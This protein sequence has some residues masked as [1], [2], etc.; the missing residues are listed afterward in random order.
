MT[1]TEP[2]PRRDALSGDGDG[3]VP[4]QRQRNAR[5]I[6]SASLIGLG[7]WT[8]HDFLPAL[9]WAA[10][11]AV[12]FWP[13]YEK[14]ERRFPPGKHNVLLPGLFTLCIGLLFG[15]PLAI[16]LFEVV[17]EF[18][19]VLDLYRQATTSGIPVPDF[20][21]H[22]PFGG[23]AVTHWWQDNLANGAQTHGI[24]ERVNKA[25]AAEIGRNVGGQIVHRTVLFFFAL[26]T[27]FFLFKQGK[28]VVRQCLDASNKA[29]GAKGERVARQMVASIHGTVDG[30]VLVGLGEG[31]LMGIAYAFAGVPHP[32]LFGAL[33]AVAAMVPFAVTVVFILV[34]AVLV[35]QGAVVAALLVVVGG[36]ILAFLADHLVRP[37]LIGGTTRLPFLWVL[38]GILGGV[39]TWGLVGLFVGP[40]LMAALVLL[41]R[42]YTEGRQAQGR[43]A[44]AKPDA[45]PVAGGGLAR[46]N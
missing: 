27:L 3:S 2:N 7:V 42:E 39:E 37:V 10:I 8:I 14:A 21:S 4:G 22:L 24:A 12:A 13:L 17:R 43:V 30:L 34:G 1:T 35:A 26:M 31:F 11:L 33:T 15:L 46:Q 40:A 44:D 38:F 25:K 36:S 41:W 45:R 28:D 9:A 16:V 29:F 6:L 23:D 18:H 5:L 19:S 32:I 20:I